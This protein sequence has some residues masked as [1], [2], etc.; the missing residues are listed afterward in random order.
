MTRATQQ[1]F[2][3]P[4]G[5]VDGA[6]RHHRHG[7][8]RLATALDEI[9]PLGDPR[10]KENEAFFGL[11]LMGRV[12]LRLGDYAPVPL[13]VIAGLYTADF[14]YLQEVYGALN[15]LEG[16]PLSPPLSPALPPSA[17]VQAPAPPI[18]A[19]PPTLETT[20]P[21]CGTELVLDLAPDALLAPA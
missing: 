17:P 20:C 1:E 13:E 3:L 16:A 10:V 8:M 19:L 7:V 21:H 2:V 5:Y 12:I 18:P 11:L 15:R 4:L 6:G 9:E 14:A